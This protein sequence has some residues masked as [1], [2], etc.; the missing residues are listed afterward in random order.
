MTSDDVVFVTCTHPTNGAEELARAVVEARLAACVQV[1]LVR[2]TYRWQ[3]VIEVAE[4][5]RL[6]IKTT[7]ARVP[8][9]EAFIRQLHPH[10][11]PEILVLRV[12]GGGADYLAWVR[13]ESAG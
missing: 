1:A 12:H 13:R 6:D 5:A 4:E 7:S 11:V 10:E 3:G 2:S 9:L 8:E